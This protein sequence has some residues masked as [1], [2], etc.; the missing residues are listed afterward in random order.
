MFALQSSEWKNCSTAGRRGELPTAGTCVADRWRI[1][2]KGRAMYANHKRLQMSSSF[3]HF[4]DLARFIDRVCETG[5][6]IGR[7]RP[8]VC[9][10][11]NQLTFDLNCLHVYGS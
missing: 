7:V 1:C 9:M 4:L 11:L 8:F 10:F 6:E 5:N 2:R 3:P